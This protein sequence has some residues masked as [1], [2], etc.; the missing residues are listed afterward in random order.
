MAA[1][2]KVVPLK[3]KTNS[4]AAALKQTATTAAP[5]AKKTS[6]P[7][8]TDVPDEIKEAVDRYIQAADQE[9]IAAAEKEASGAQVI[10]YTRGVQDK[11]GFAGRFRHSYGVPG[12]SG[13]QVKFVSSNRFSIDAADEERIQAMLGDA[14]DQMIEKK[15]SVVLK[16]EVLA[17]EALQEELMELI[18]DRFADFFTSKV[19]LAVK[20]G[21]DQQVF[22][23]V[24]AEDLPELRTICRPYKPSLR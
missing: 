5:K 8:L 7:V 14:F 10:E 21:F 23:V 6:V 17:S 24:K 12:N 13:K 1:A 22:N 11:D 3:P 20:E 19:A 15:V 4:F 18:G 16:D 9:K 2:A